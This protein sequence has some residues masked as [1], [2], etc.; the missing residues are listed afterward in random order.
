MNIIIR[1]ETQE[2]HSPVEQI[3][4]SAFRTDAES[5][6]VNAIRAFLRFE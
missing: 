5:K 1:A 2:D 6:V 4:R 3:H